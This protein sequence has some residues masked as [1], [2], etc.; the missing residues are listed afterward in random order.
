MMSIVLPRSLNSDIFKNMRGLQ[1]AVRV[2]DSNGETIYSV[3]PVTVEVTRASK[4]EKLSL[5]FLLDLEN[6]Q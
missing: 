4:L 6:T 5:R 3:E 1:I 2:Q